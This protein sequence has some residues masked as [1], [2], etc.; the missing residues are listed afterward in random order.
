MRKSLAI[1]V[2]L[3]L[4]NFGGGC[5]AQAPKDTPS[6]GP[7]N[8]IAAVRS[9]WVLD[10][11]TKQLEPFLVLYTSDAGFM[12]PD[13]SRLSG[14]DAIHDFMELVFAEISSNIVLESRHTDFSGNMA[15]DSGVYWETLT[16]LKTGAKQKISGSYLMILRHEPDGKWRIAQQMFTQGSTPS[17][18]APAG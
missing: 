9:E 11:Q 1:A 17:G 18:R 5:K 2:L 15:Y 6:Q 14:H 13:G 4:G 3:V 10:L 8:E 16:S 12:T 7:V